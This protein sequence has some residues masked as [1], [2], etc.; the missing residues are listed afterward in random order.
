MT[1]ETVLPELVRRESRSFLQY[2][3]ESFPWAAGKDEP[4]RAALLR[5]AE[6]EGAYAGKI[7]RLMQKRHIPMPG[8]GAY[9]SSFTNSNFLAVR[10]LVPKL[11]AGERQSLTDLERD[12]FRVTDGEARTV[13]DS[14]RELKRQHLSE[15]EALAS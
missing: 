7:G 1:D 4:V 12:L 14:F 15:L 6:A 2:V 8:L 10:S 11:L 5:M 3:R 9:P 13:L